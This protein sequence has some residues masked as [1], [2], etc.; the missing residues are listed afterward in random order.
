MG[1]QVYIREKE[2]RKK[3]KDEKEERKGFSLFGK[4][5]TLKKK[6]I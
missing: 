3:K 1:G 5:K 4:K 2:K 6:N